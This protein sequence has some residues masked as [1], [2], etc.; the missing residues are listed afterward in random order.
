MIARLVVSLLLLWILVIKIGDNWKQAAPDPKASTFAWLFGALVLTFGAVVLSAVR[1]RAVLSA[2]DLHPPFN[3][4]LSLYFAGQ[5][6]GNVLPS[7][8]GGDALRVSRLSKET[9]ETPITF[10]SVVLER[11]S[12]WVVLPL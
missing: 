3:R 1:W 7:T 10:A 12:G 6:M 9:G 5:F 11:M 2:L 8:I 4:L